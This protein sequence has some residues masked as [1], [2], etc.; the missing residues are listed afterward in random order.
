MRSTFL[1]GVFG[2][3]EGAATSGE[4][5]ECL[6]FFGSDLVTEVFFGT[7]LFGGAT[8]LASVALESPGFSKVEALLPRGGWVNPVTGSI[9]VGIFV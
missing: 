5:T 1:R 9:N 4:G 8:L 7:D 6:S 2:L 3:G